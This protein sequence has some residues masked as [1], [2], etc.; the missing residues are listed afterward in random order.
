MVSGGDGQ[1]C[2]LVGR[3]HQLGNMCERT[4]NFERVG[5]L[6]G[7]KFEEDI[8]TAAWNDGCRSDVRVESGTN[9]AEICD[10]HYGPNLPANSIH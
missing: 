3:L 4:S 9:V 8:R 6:K 2:S 10:R 1:D 7:F 5:V